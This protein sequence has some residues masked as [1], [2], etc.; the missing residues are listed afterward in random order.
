MRR[1]RYPLSPARQWKLIIE[2]A[3]RQ[4]SKN[5]GAAALSCARTDTIPD[6]SVVGI[7]VELPADKNTSKMPLTRDVGPVVIYLPLQRARGRT[8]A[9]SYNMCVCVCMIG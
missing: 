8:E 1:P 2:L 7:L 9:A 5:K 3:A 6:F 4:A